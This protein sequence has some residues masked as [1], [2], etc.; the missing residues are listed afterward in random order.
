[1]NIFDSPS[2]FKS[3]IGPRC[4]I[5]TRSVRSTQEE[6]RRLFQVPPE[7]DLLGNFPGKNAVFPDSEAPVVRA[8]DDGGREMLPMRGRMPGPVK[9]GGL[10]VTN[11][12][13]PTSPLGAAG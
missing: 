8:A 5:C 4:A 7:R 13:N 9:F 2:L 12:R 1:M 10:P 6:L 3:R 11:I